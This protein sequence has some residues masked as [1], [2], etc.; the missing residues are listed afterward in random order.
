MIGSSYKLS[1]PI[2]PPDEQ[3]VRKLIRDLELALAQINLECGYFIDAAYTWNPGSLADGVG[4]TSGD[5]AVEGATLGNFV[6]VGAPYDLQGITCMGYVQAVDVV[7]IRL[8][9]ESGGV[10]DLGEGVWKVRVIKSA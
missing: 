8:Q 6:L 3:Y 4:E 1:A 7:H 5:I 2:G 9:N 10:I